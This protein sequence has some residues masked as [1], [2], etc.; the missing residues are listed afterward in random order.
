MPRHQGL[1]PI[2]SFGLWAFPAPVAQLTTIVA[3]GILHLLSQLT[4][5]LFRVLLLV[6]VSHLLH[7]GHALL[8]S[9]LQSKSLLLCLDKLRRGIFIKAFLTRFTAKT[10]SVL[11]AT[12]AH[13][14]KVL[15]RKSPSVVVLAVVEGRF[16]LN[17]VFLAIDTRQVW[18]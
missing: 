6:E 16:S 9:K 2:L 3:M 7:F 11:H 13:C 5:S 4:P 15:C 18:L 8:S 17:Q 10:Q 14:I 1:L 12:F